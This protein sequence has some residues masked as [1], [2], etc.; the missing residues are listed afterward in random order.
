MFFRFISDSVQWKRDRTSLSLIEM[1]C[2]FCAGMLCSL[3]HCLG[4]CCAPHR[5]ARRARAFSEVCSLLRT[6]FGAVSVLSNIFSSVNGSMFDLVKSLFVVA[7]P[8]DVVRILF[9]GFSP[10]EVARMFTKLG[11]STNRSVFVDQLCLSL[12]HMA[13]D[14]CP[15]L[16]APPVRI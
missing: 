12:F 3:S 9:G 6:E 2:T 7:S 5:V 11:S 16:E 8:N 14:L 10:K 13:C 4:V 15:V 1:K